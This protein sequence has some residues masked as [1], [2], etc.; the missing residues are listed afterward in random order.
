MQMKNLHRKI[1]RPH[2]KILLTLIVYIFNRLE[3]LTFRI[4]IS[5][6]KS[7]LLVKAVGM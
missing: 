3:A 7:S 4:A 2:I 5:V 1:L 6:R